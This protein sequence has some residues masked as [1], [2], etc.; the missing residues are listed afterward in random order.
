MDGL[1]R[2]I[3]GTT[4][5]ILLPKRMIQGAHT[6]LRTTTAFFNSPRPSTTGNRKQDLL[7]KYLHLL[8]RIFTLANVKNEQGTF[9][10]ND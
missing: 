10:A 9:E 3:S 2:M 1:T 7:V 8:S 4:T 5:T 6:H